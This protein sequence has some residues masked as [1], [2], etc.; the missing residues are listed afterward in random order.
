MAN[1]R[2]HGV[3]RDIIKHKLEVNLSGK[4][5]K[6]KLRKMS[7]EKVAVVKADVQRLLDAGFIC[8]VQYPSW[9]ANIIMVKKKNSKWRMCIDFTDINK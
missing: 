8:E 6:L 1:L 7:D 2:S 5:K 9:L 4:P 3:S